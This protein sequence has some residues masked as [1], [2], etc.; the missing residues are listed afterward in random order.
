MSA[1]IIKQNKAL[2]HQFT[3]AGVGLIK[4]G[5]FDA[6][7]ERKKARARGISHGA[8]QIKSDMMLSIH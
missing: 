8:I 7:I 5:R 1:T 4:P 6:L 2:R 3:F